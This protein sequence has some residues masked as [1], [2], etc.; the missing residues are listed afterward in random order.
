MFRT[1]PLLLASCLVL[2]AA[3]PAFAKDKPKAAKHAAIIATEIAAAGPDFEIQGEYVA[4]E[5]KAHGKLMKYGVQV[6]AL[7]DGK[8]RAVGYPGGLP[9]DGWDE[10]TRN[11]ADGQTKDGETTFIANKAETITIR[12]G[13]MTFSGK[14][15]TLGTL[16]KTVGRW[17]SSV[18]NIFSGKGRSGSRAV[19]PPTPSGK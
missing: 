6:V 17:R 7:G 19:V 2:A 11:E 4:E 12:D 3:A 1:L 8:F 10:K 18:S 9:G 13:V 16:K 15:E 5:I 14:G